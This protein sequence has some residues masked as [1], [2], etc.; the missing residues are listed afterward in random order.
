MA[1]LE[2][3]RNKPLTGHGKTDLSGLR[4][5]FIIQV[6]SRMYRTMIYNLQPL[7]FGGIQP[8][9]NAVYP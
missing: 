5:K 2:S 7:T 6:K 1:Y 9:V 4:N 3:V 8:G